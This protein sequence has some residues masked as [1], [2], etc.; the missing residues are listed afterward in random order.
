MDE[1]HV[2]K[3][4][5]SRVK[6]QKVGFFVLFLLLFCGC[7]ARVDVIV[8]TKHTMEEVSY[9][10]IPKEHVTNYFSSLDEARRYYNSILSDY[11][12]KKEKYSFELFY[13]NNFA[14]G[15]INKKGKLEN[16]KFEGIETLLFKEIK[17]KGDLY[18][19]LLSDKVLEYFGS[20]LEMEIDEEFILK[21]IVLNIQ[22]HNVV[23]NVNSDSY[24]SRSNTYT[25]VINKDNLNREIEFTI[26]N[27][28]RYDIIMAYLFKKYIDFVFL[29]VF[30][31]GIGLFIVYIIRKS[32]RENAI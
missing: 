18:K 6:K 19:I 10:S 3:E 16:K 9:I 21:E 24:N 29:G 2:K 7:S 1:N 4:R 28:K 14:L 26:T 31:L 22:F 17:Q 15:K 13:K 20:E 32:K 5:V 12:T 30:L 25:W 23:E 8:D 11:G 27:T